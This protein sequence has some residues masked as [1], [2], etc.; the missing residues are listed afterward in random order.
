MKIVIA[1]MLVLAG[2]ATA[3]AQYISP[4]GSPRDSS[5]PGLYGS[6]SGSNPNNH[7]VSPHTTPQGT[8]VAPHYQTSPNSTQMDNYG[9]RGNQIPHTGQF[10]TRAPRY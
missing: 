7:Y 5:N 10:G 1:L 8:Y 3:A 2:A 6:G 9:T 4:Y